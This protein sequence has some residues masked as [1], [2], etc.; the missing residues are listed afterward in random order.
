MLG[1]RSQ[2]EMVSQ[3]VLAGIPE[4][5]PINSGSSSQSPAAATGTDGSGKNRKERK[6]KQKR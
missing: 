6:E 3:Q 1:L 2:T 4:G 5:F